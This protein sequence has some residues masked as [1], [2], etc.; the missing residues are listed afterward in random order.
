MNRM[1]E[2]QDMLQELESIPEAT[3]ECVKR[4][5]ARRRRQRL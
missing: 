5:V 2:Y 1:E 3:A 4:A